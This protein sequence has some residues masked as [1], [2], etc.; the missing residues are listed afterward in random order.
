MARPND[1][2]GGCSKRSPWGVSA[3]GI[4]FAAG[5]IVAGAS[6]LALPFPGS[7][8]EPMWQLNPE[9]RT[10]LAPLAPGPWL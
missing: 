8:L 1:P 4:F 9:A 2:E 10:L 7:W 3:L 5:F 6:A